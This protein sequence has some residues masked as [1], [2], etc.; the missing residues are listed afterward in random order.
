MREK[1]RLES[2]FAQLALAAVM[3]AIILVAVEYWRSWKGERDL[4]GPSQGTAVAYPIAAVRSASSLSPAAGSVGGTSHVPMSEADR[5]AEAHL[6]AQLR[7]AADALGDA[8]ERVRILGEERDAL[9]AERDALLDAGSSAEQSVAEQASHAQALERALA[10]RESELAQITEHMASLEA[11]RDDLAQRLGQAE[12]NVG[13]RVSVLER[14]ILARD[15]ELATAEA[16]IAEL[17][18]A[19]RL[20]AAGGGTTNAGT[21]GGQARRA[22]E[23]AA[24]ALPQPRRSANTGTTANT[25]GTA[26]RV[27]GRTSSGA[28]APIAD[29]EA[30]AETTEDG[31]AAYNAGDYARAN[32]IWQSLAENG[33]PRAQ[34]H[35]GSLLY[36]GRL[37]QP[38]LVQAY[39]W[40][41]RSAQRGF[42]PALAMRE[43]VRASMTRQQLDEARTRLG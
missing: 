21:A 35:L 24:G 1:S 41:T 23:P 30:P 16:R 43:R 37:G 9:M 42:G 25:S 17:T 4:A 3:A 12:T 28:D 7:A 14:T 2:F 34:F 39:I 40:L 32:R 5:A 20:A 10:Q 13:E 15:A 8:N 33:S 11:E 22:P 38:D 31:V 36:E 27:A 29:Q 18:R 6:E 19:T 26:T